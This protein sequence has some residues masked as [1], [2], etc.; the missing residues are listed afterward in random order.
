MALSYK[1][2]QELYGEA[3]S[4]KSEWEGLLRVIAHHFD[5]TK[6]DFYTPE[7]SR[8]V[9]EFSQLTD[10]SGVRYAKQ[11]RN[12]VINRA[13]PD[14]SDWCKLSIAP[15][16]RAK[17]MAQSPQQVLS[18]E[19]DLEI[20]SRALQDTLAR[21][22]FRNAMKQQ[23][24]D[25]LIFGVSA[26]RPRISPR[27]GMLTFNTFGPNTVDLMPTD[28]A[29]WGGLF[30]R[31]YMKV[32]DIK[33]DYP[34]FQNKGGKPDSETVNLIFGYVP[35]KEAGYEVAF[36]DGEE[37]FTYLK[38][39]D[40]RERRVIAACYEASSGETYGT[41]LGAQSLPEQMMRDLMRSD[42]LE[43]NALAINPVY[44]YDQGALQQQPRDIVI[45]PGNAIPV[46][47]DLSQGLPIQPLNTGVDPSK[48][49]AILE[50]SKQQTREDMGI[51][52]RAADPAQPVRSATEWIYARAQADADNEEVMMAVRDAVIIP[53][54]KQ[55]IKVIQRDTGDLPAELD[56]E[57]GVFAIE[58]IG[59]DEARVKNERTLS[60]RAA[61]ESAQT[62]V[63]PEVVMAKVNQAKVV[64]EFFNNTGNAH[65]L[66]TEEEQK[67]ITD[68]LE[69]QRQ[70]QQQ[71]G[72]LQ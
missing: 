14:K 61:L 15:L 18:M 21:S 72:A 58:L 62:H 16:A 63:A 42:V 47:A 2:A 55:A 33:I 24:G 13:L 29:D 43:A 6:S 48:N 44:L 40:P 28:D 54:V 56:L 23:C 12:E 1:E 20:M 37:G 59:Y 27:T 65:L 38:R 22:N 3:T 9:N 66:N 4:R 71:A 51:G 26:G 67:R 31:R 36:V 34:E 70:Q 30:W 8:G 25:Y 7:T 50:E 53:N 45:A 52:Q 68:D 5:P 46:N 10:G 17:I 64:D 35:M 60:L 69:A 19:R 39:Y 57:S 49:F 11:L 41:A 32:R